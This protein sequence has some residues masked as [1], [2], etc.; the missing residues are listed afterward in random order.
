MADV[1]VPPNMARFMPNDAVQNV[2]LEHE[3]FGSD[4]DLS[5]EEYVGQSSVVLL[6]I[7]GRPDTPCVP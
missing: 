1:S 7:P 4:S 5:E 2:D 3:I 6:R